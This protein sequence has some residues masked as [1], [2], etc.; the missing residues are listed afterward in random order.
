MP[1][2]KQKSHPTSVKR[3]GKHHKHGQ[4]YMKVYWPYM[5]LLFITV[6]GLFV[7][8]TDHSRR[9]H[10]VLSYST[11]IGSSSLL[12]ATNQQRKNN[13][14]AELVLSS[15]LSSA[16][17]AK[18]DDMAKRNYW[19]HN[20]PD[21]KEPWIFIQKAG[22]SYQKAGENLAYGFVTS[23]DTITGWMNSPGH[24]ANLLDK[25]Y[26]EVGFGFANVA[27]YQSSG[28]ETI[29][30]AEYGTPLTDSNGPVPS[31]AVPGPD[32]PVT[33]AQA[34]LSNRSTT[35]SRMQSLARGKA[36]AW[37]VFLVGIVGGGAVVYLIIKHAIGLRKLVV[38]GETFFLHHPLVDA[39]LM[40]LVFVCVYLSQTVGFIR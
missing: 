37:S 5:P 23:N 34:V 40:A 2:A 20:T 24:R 8:L 1:S 17:Q 18:A 6:L 33:S 39:G 29:V 21:G 11:E 28:P 14:Q 15:K 22:Y 35:V 30:V 27:D 36:P 3:H 16:A 10:G 25:S 19:A 31:T 32:S 12:N 38:K 26:K 9:Q 7:L 13:N 4:H